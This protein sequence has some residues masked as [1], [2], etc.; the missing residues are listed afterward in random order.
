MGDDR[1]SDMGGFNDAQTFD[2]THK[3]GVLEELD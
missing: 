3:S 1:L 2:E